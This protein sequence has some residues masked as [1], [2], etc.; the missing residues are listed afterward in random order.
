M[1]YQNY[2]DYMRQVLGYS[3]NDPIIYEP[4][5]YRNYGNTYYSDQYASNLSEEEMQQFYPEIYH[6]L[7]P[8]VCKICDSN[9]QP[10]TRELIEIMTDEIYN[11]MED[12]TTV[13]NVRVDA[14]KE[15]QRNR[16]QNTEIRRLENR[17]EKENT[18]PELDRGNKLTRDNRE[19]IGSKDNSGNM[20]DRQ[21]QE[22]RE[23]R[24]DRRISNPTLRDLIKILILNRLLRKNRPH[25][26]RP[27]F[28]PHG[29][30]GMPPPRPPY[31]GGR[32][33]MQ[34]RDYTTF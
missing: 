2:E 32:S 16:N 1:N 20:E 25:R 14:K 30:P 6:L 23:T 5:D 24:Q 15:E 3:S 33:P 13:V 31:P 17:T 34:P 7:N 18:R 21:K 19:I 27:P 26:P 12:N 11:A 4:Y 10:I 29:G 9:T 8:M 22:N 28:P